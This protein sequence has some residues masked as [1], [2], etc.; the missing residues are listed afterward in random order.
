MSSSVEVNSTSS[1]TTITTKK[2]KAIKPTA[3]PV[4]TAAEQPKGDKDLMVLASL[5]FG[6]ADLA[7]KP[8]EEVF[9]SYCAT[10]AAIASSKAAAAPYV[11]PLQYSYKYDYHDSSNIKVEYNPRPVHRIEIDTDFPAAE[12]SFGSSDKRK[13]KQKTA[14]ATGIKQ[15][16][17]SCYAPQQSYGQQS[18]FGGGSDYSAQFVPGSFLFDPSAHFVQ[19]AAAGQPEL[20]EINFSAAQSCRGNSAYDMSFMFAPAP[21]TSQ[22]PLC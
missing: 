21:V 10:A 8:I 11:A 6:K 3:P 1:S 16:F 9:Q 12:P 20:G 19:S 18:A 22:Q 14:Q 15:A 2:T 17:S 4:A 7:Q 5:M 13:P